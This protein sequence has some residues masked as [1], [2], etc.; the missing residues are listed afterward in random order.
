MI[1][2]NYHRWHHFNLSIITTIILG[3]AKLLLLICGTRIA[4][5]TSL[6]II[7]SVSRMSIFAVFVLLISDP[8]VRGRCR[9]SIWWTL[10]CSPLVDVHVFDAVTDGFE[11]MEMP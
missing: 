11:N 5:I 6:F 8:P 2:K 4:N 10:F 3:F 1:H 9:L 7:T